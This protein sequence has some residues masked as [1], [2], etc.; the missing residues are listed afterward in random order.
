VPLGMEI[1]LGPG[2]IMLDGDPAPGKVGNPKFSAHVY[3]GQTGRWITCA[4]YG[5]L[6]AVLDNDRVVWS[7]CH[8]SEPC[9]KTAEPIEMSFGLRTQMDI[10]NHVLDGGPD[11]SM[12]RG[13]FE[14]DKGR[15]SVKYT[16][17]EVCK[18]S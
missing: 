4:T 12:G 2:D 16:V 11:P 14:G 6:L 1:G 18:N 15:P 7:V 9:K 8:T 17:T 10:R 3:Y 5:G 13:N